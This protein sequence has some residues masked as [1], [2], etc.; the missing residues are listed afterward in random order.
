MHVTGVAG[1]IVPVDGVHKTRQP[2][3]KMYAANA[4]VTGA[5]RYCGFYPP[6]QEA[7]RKGKKKTRIEQSKFL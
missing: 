5:N 1:G 4:K 3:I 7:A 2:C 6:S